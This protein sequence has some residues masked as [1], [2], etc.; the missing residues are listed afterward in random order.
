MTQQM[1]N[2]EVDTALILEGEL[3]RRVSEVVEK[4]VVN[5]VGKIIHQE[6]NKYKAEM[7][8]EV[9][10]NVGRMLR[11]VENEGRKPLWEAKPEEFG[12]THEDLN[13]SSI[14][15]LDEMQLVQNEIKKD[16][17]HAVREQT[18]TI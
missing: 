15:H 18:P 1:P 12:L 16:I 17:D 8:M 9:S 7:L 10:I 6:L 4:V 5:M 3:K 13:R 2:D 14:R 11:M